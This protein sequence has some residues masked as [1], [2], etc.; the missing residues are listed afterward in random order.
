[1]DEFIEH[2]CPM[3][4]YKFVNIVSAPFLTTRYLYISPISTL[5][6]TSLLSDIQKNSFFHSFILSIFISIS[7]SISLS[8]KLHTKYK[9]WKDIGMTLLSLSKRF[10][11][12]QT[13]VSLSNRVI[14]RGTLD[15]PNSF[16]R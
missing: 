16:N 10:N 3:P 12:E 14:A 6:I 9:S 4:K 15:D 11:K 5:F 1:M 2:L 13:V 7:I 8:S